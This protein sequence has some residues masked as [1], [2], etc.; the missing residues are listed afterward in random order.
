M[1]AKA[2]G[3]CLPPPRGVTLCGGLV[4]VARGAECL[5]VSGA[6]VAS[7]SLGLDVVDNISCCDDAFFLAFLTQIGIS[8]ENP[9]S[10][11]APCPT[12]TTLGVRSFFLLPLIPAVLSLLVLFTV[13]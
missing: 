2:V 12:V 10:E 6:V 11:F 8:F 4:V 5:Q 1:R 9:S 3:I 7:L 13:A